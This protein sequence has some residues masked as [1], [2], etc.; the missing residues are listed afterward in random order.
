M[1]EKQAERR[2]ARNR[3]RMSKIHFKAVGHRT[4]AM[5]ALERAGHGEI[6]VRTVRA[7]L[8]TPFEHARV[9][10]ALLCY[11]GERPAY[12]R[13]DRLEE[14]CHHFAPLLKKTT[15]QVWAALA[16]EGRR[17]RRERKPV[18]HRWARRGG[19]R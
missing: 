19:A 6:K 15:P 16:A 1:T 9:T 10:E 5:Y 8:G 11:R 18:R 7:V 17:W 13:A 4:R 2:R 14:L 3:R 12:I